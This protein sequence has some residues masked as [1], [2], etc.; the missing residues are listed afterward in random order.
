MRHYRTY[1]K[2]MLSI[3]LAALMCLSF[4]AL[5]VTGI[6]GKDQ[7]AK[8]YEDNPSH[9]YYFT[10]KQGSVES[11][12]DGRDGETTF[13]VWGRNADG[14][15][16]EQKIY[17]SGSV[18]GCWAFASGSD[19]RGDAN[20]GEFS[21]SYFPTKVRVGISICDNS[22]A[23]GSKK[24]SS[25]VVMHVKKS[26]GSWTSDTVWNFSFTSSTNFWGGGYTWKE[27]TSPEFST[28]RPYANSI[29]MA[30]LIINRFNEP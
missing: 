8:A 20:T 21:S 19:G 6:F 25:S 18:S 2:K 27:K 7:T 10:I 26:D 4:V 23:V 16:S 24:I 17:S 9:T 1:G 11:N 12:Y 30:V 3:F 28:G 5:D 22:S 15:G 29:G 13:E 14:T